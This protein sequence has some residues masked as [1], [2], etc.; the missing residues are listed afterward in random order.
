M[1]CLG[2]GLVVYVLQ[3]T[4]VD[5]HKGSLI[6]L[7]LAGIPAPGAKSASQILYALAEVGTLAFL[8]PRGQERQLHQHN[9]RHT[10][11]HQLGR[12][13]GRAAPCIHGDL[14][15]GILSAEFISQQLGEIQN[16]GHIAKIARIKEVGDHTIGVGSQ[17]GVNIIILIKAGQHVGILIGGLFRIGVTVGNASVVPTVSVK[18]CRPA[19]NGKVHAVL[20]E[21]VRQNFISIV[22]DLPGAAG[23][24]GG[25]HIGHLNA[26]EAASFHHL[27]VVCQL[28]VGQGHKIHHQGGLHIADESTV[29]VHLPRANGRFSFRDPRL[30]Y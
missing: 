22:H 20:M 2:S 15:I 29:V 5:N 26:R 24:P 28:T 27:N 4:V 21:L 6:L 14:D 3:N 1:V 18:L 12:I 10:G 23:T 17:I 7:V 13:S 9:V 30:L 16:A 19:P 11:V 8:T 25:Y